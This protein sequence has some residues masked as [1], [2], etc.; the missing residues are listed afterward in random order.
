LDRGWF[1]EPTVFADVDNRS[2]IAQEEIF[3]PVLTIIGYDDVDDAIRL[4]NDS[5]FGLG[6]TVWTTD[7]ERGEAVARRVQ[8]GTVG[9]ATRSG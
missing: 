5:D 8:T 4:A 3:G 6:G 9:T 2:T 1:V 7:V